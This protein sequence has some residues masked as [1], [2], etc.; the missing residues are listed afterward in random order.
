MFLLLWR[1]EVPINIIKKLSTLLHPWPHQ[2]PPGPSSTRLAE[3]LQGASR[4]SWRG[5]GRCCEHPTTPGD[6][7]SPEQETCWLFK[8][9]VRASVSK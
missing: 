7:V 1:S 2:G 8:S 4:S 6:S 3:R 5:C 9:R